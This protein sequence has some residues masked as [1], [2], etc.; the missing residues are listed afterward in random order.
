MRI[1]STV[2][3]A[4]L[5]FVVSVDAVADDY[6]SYFKQAGV[7]VTKVIGQTGSPLGSGLR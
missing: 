6:L 7:E 2:V 3:V 5:A 1:I 4:Y